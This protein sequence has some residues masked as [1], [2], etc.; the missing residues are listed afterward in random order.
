MDFLIQFA[1]KYLNFDISS[2]LKSKRE[3]GELKYVFIENVKHNRI[4]TY[5]RFII[6]NLSIKREEL[7]Y[8]TFL[9]EPKEERNLFDLLF[10]RPVNKQ[11]IFNS[12]D[13]VKINEAFGS[14]K[15][16]YGQ[17]LE[18]GKKI[19]IYKKEYVVKEISITIADYFNDYSFTAHETEIQNIGQSTPYNIIVKL[20]V[21]NI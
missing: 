18:V 14:I 19:K 5:P 8:K 1:I 16:N 7:D 6:N 20:D 3:D 13:F 12:S 10:Q 11:N 9:N 4:P 21:E 2:F 15:P 17:T